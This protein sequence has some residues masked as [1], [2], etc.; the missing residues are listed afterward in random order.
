MNH[1]GQNIDKLESPNVPLASAVGVV[2]T[3][4]LRNKNS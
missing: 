3:E 1:S 2:V 4:I